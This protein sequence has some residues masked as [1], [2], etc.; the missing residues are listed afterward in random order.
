MFICG[1]DVS[2][3][4][5]LELRLLV[6]DDD[7][8]SRDLL[9]D[10]L[11][12]R[13]AK[14]VVAANACEATDAFRQWDPDVLISDIG[15]PGDDGYDLIRRLRELGAESGKRMPAIACSSHAATEDRAAALEAGFNAFVAKPIDLDLLVDTIAHFTDVGFGGSND[16]PTGTSG[17]MAEEGG[18]GK[19]APDS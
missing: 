3:H 11:R 6:V 10:A 7:S 13:G 5:E 8:N 4:A 12:I 14:V 9:S 17:R 19:S 18:R 15:M 16:A 1:D 2:V